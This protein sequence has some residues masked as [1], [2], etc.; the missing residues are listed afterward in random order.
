MILKKAGDDLIQ[1]TKFK[2][3]EKRKK[4]VGYRSYSLVLAKLLNHCH[5]QN[6]TVMYNCI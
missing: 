1:K 5:W 3:K 6:S 2:G 4:K